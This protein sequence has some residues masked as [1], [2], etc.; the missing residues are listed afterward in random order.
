M[1][2]TITITNF[3]RNTRLLA[4]CAIDTRQAA[5][6]TTGFV[7]RLAR[8]TVQVA[9][10]D[11]DRVRAQEQVARPG[12]DKPCVECERVLRVRERR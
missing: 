7:D 1:I 5:S 12:S 10:T 2:V 11:T 4:S 6:S 3:A 8:A 9:T